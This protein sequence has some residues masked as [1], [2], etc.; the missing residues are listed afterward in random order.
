MRVPALSFHIFEKT[1]QFSTMLRQ[2]KVN[3][4]NHII[5]I[6]GKFTSTLLT[7]YRMCQIKGPSSAEITPANH[8]SL[9]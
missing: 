7:M 9:R 5:G 4:P 2:G 3:A 6:I 1:A 8:Q